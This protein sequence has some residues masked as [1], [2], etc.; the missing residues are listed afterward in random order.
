MLCNSSAVVAITCACFRCLHM[1]HEPETYRDSWLMACLA[2]ALFVV[3]CF[4]WRREED[5][6]P[7][8]LRAAVFKTAAID[9]SAIP[10]YAHRVASANRNLTLHTGRGPMDSR[11]R[12]ANRARDIHTGERTPAL[13]DLLY[14]TG[15]PGPNHSDGGSGAVRR[16]PQ[17]VTATPD[18]VPPAETAGKRAGRMTEAGTRRT[19]RHQGTAACGGLKP[20]S[21][22]G[23]S[24][25]L[26]L[27]KRRHS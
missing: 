21:V 3:G 24:G 22:K 19:A 1:P 12:Q 26:L 7:R 11:N 4:L 2:Y 15:L 10:P 5:S 18:S 25:P 27:L 17:N 20:H 9:H 13:P 14:A 23:A 6:N 16:A 8:P